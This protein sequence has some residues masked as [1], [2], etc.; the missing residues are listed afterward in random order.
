M[1]L[2][3]TSILGMRRYFLA[4]SIGCPVVI[5]GKESNANLLVIDSCGFEVIL[6]WIG[7]VPFTL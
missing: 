5:G 2:C 1:N 6:E 4:K 7:C 3:R